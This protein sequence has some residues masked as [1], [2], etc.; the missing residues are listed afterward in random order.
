MHPGESCLRLKCQTLAMA[1][2][3]IARVEQTPCPNC[4]GERE[5]NVATTCESL[6]ESAKPGGPRPVFVLLIERRGLT[7][8]LACL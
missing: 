1:E 5:P 2:C 7:S 6:T 3:C 8:S 4:R